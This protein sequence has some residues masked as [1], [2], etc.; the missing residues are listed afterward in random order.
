LAAS[1]VVVDLSSLGN[2]PEYQV[3]AAQLPDPQARALLAKINDLD[4]P[5]GK[6]RQATLEAVRAF[7]GTLGVSINAEK[8]AI[9]RDRNAR[10]ATAAIKEKGLNKPPKEGGGRTRR[11]RRTMRHRR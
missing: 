1:V 2:K 9:A 8:V 10:A 6:G 7:I 5:V 3:L 11:K 4:W